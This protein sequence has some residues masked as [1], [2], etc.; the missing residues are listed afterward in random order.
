[1]PCAGALSPFAPTGLIATNLMG[2]M[3][4]PGHEWPIYLYNLLANLSVA[5]IG[6][7]AFGG[8]QLFNRKGQI[9]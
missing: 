4:L 7:V 5:S 9:A 2:R 8:W 6:Y 1:M 3:G